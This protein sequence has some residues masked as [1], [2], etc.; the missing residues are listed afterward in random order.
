MYATWPCPLPNGRMGEE[1]VLGFDAARSQRLLVI[2]PLFDEANK[3]R[4]QIF[5]IIR[6]IHLRE[7]DC[8]LPDLPGCNESTADFTQQ[9]L[10]NW[11]A[12]VAAAAAHFR[13]THV[14]AIRSGGWL[15]PDAIP[16]WLYAPVK[17]RQVLR[18][19]L[20]ARIIAA[21]EAGRD[22]TADGLLA[23][24]RTEGIE[25]AGW[26]LGAQLVREL[27][28]EE[29]PSTGAPIVIEHSDVGGQPLWLRAENDDD[30]EQADALAAIVAIGIHGL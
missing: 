29:S 24:A 15:V 14:L 9:S 30:P 28:A 10:A 5:E 17:P 11:R 25:L 18:S 21:R 1:M 3:F 27:E 23:M 22:E 7:V 19:L 2:P 6:R 12:A 26:P 4:H 16:A 8:F 13:A 20:R